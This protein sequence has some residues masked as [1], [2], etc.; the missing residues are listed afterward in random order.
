MKPLVSIL[1]PAYNAERWIGDTI[2]SALAQTWTRRE[3][4][5][6]D[7]GSRDKTVEIA[8]Q[9]AAAGVKVVT[10]PNAGAAAA[11]NQAYALCQGDYIQW[12]DA[13]DLLSPDKITRQMQ[14]AETT[15][16]RTLLSCGWGFFCYRPQR[17][18]FVPSRL[19][20]D[21]TPLEWLLRKWEHNLF[22]QTGT[23]LTS[24][25][26]SG[27][28]GPWNAQMMGDD[29]G[30]FF[31][32]VIKAADG[33]RFVPEA[34]VYYRISGAGRLSYISRS[35]KKMDAQF[36][37]MQIQIGYL[38]AMADDERVRAT[39]VTYLQNWLVNFYPER[40]DLVAA[41]RK[42]AAELGGELQPPQLSW[43]Y[44]WIQKAFGW[45][46]ARAAAV[47]YNEWKAAALRSWDRMMFQI[48]GGRVV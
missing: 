41:A 6:V 2:K 13:D 28:A 11:R 21:L 30:E 35:D 3:I 29:D 19:W 14:V 32:R 36:L 34:R 37:G 1:I 18:K 31:F 20:E 26:L 38:R 23:W 25:E 16:P 45:P 48:E 27:L 10:Q 4:I 40:M 43:K 44:R 9:F 46:A 12:L 8:R 17:A 5:V 22:M 42:L 33:I 47:N 24:R 15:G 39:C 7:D